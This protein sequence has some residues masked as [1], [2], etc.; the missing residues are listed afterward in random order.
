MMDL[1]QKNNPKKVVKKSILIPLYIFSLSTIIEKHKTN[2]G[3]MQ[4]I[5]IARLTSMYFTA[6]SKPEVS[7]IEP[8][9]I[10]KKSIRFF[11]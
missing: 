2:I 5:N 7:R 11:L 8:T 9:V 3:Y 1:I 4:K 6:S 10:I